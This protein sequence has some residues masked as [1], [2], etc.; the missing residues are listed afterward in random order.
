MRSSVIHLVLAMARLLTCR[1]TNAQKQHFLSST[2]APNYSARKGEERG[3]EGDKRGK[4]E[5]E[6]K[7]RKENARKTRVQLKRPCRQI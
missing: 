7:I 6:W 3:K 1:R 5:E 2:L 4:R